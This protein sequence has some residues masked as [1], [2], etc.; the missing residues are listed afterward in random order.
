MWW[1]SLADIAANER[2]TVL[3][4]LF[5]QNKLLDCTRFESFGSL[6]DVKYSKPHALP[7][8]I[9]CTIL[10]IFGKEFVVEVGFYN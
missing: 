5:L 10:A 4:L 9:F 2:E 3:F 7:P 8:L 6:V 1:R